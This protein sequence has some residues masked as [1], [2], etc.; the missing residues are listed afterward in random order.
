MLFTSKRI[1]P[2]TYFSRGGSHA[3]VRSGMGARPISVEAASRESSDN[4]AECAFH[5]AEAAPT[6]PF[7]QAW[8]PN[9]LY[10]TFTHVIP[11]EPLDFAWD[12]RPRERGIPMMSLLNSNHHRDSHPSGM[13][14]SR[15][16]ALRMTPSLCHPERIDDFVLEI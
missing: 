13:I 6:P 16:S 3:A 1:H 11:S 14:A 2:N 7:G 15:L 4:E 12:L 9:L 10:D 8:E 5:S